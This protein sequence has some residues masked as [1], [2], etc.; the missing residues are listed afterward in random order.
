M[1]K[2]LISLLLAFSVTI[3][4]IYSQEVS[5]RKDIAVMQVYSSYNIPDAAYMYFDDAL[6]SILSRM[7]RFQVIGY[8]YRLDNNSAE[9]FI[10]KVQEAK[11]QA[12]LQNPQYF[13]ADLG[14]AVIPASEMEKLANSF[15]VFIPSITG[16]STKEYKIKIEQKKGNRI[17]VDFVTEY[18]ADVSVS[19]KTI[20]ADGNLMD[21][22]MRSESKKSRTSAIDA[23]QQAAL[24]ALS[25]IEFHLRNVEEFKIKSKVLQVKDDLVYLELGRNLGIKPG[26]EFFV[27]KE[28][29]IAGQFSDTIDTALVRVNYVGDKWSS[30]TTI[31]GY[32]QAN[33]QLI[34]APIMGARFNIFLGMV[35]MVINGSD[36]TLLYSSPGISFIS[37]EKFKQSSYVF[38]AGI[39]MEYEL[40]Y[41]ALIDL[42][43]GAIFNDPFAMN[44][45]IGG[46]YEM[47]F[48]RMSVTLGADLSAVGLIRYLGTYKN[49]SEIEINGTTFDDDIRVDLMGATIGLKPKVTFNYQISQHFKIRLTGGYAFYFLPFYYLKF[50]STSDSDTSTTVDTTDSRI[51]MI[52]NGEESTSLPI[53]FSGPFGGLEFILRF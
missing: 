36:L 48:G 23:Y 3:G 34:E 10:K 26:Y 9:T 28:T 4:V 15:F 53:S 27:R 7:K 1:K 49:S 21:T 11:K 44:L 12:A 45:D 35:P 32:P 40:G 20:T 38:S 16:Y 31:Y 5:Q 41:A 24:A 19:I 6:I 33:D 39:N 50:S 47:Y 46:G 8:H 30:A 43:I 29:Q 13:D 18:Q 37:T 14:V 2:I 22:Y 52:L 51:K 42:S 25:G 17:V